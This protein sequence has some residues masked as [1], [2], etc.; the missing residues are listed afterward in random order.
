MADI[1]RDLQHYQ[2]QGTAPTLAKANERVQAARKA[3]PLSDL[4]HFRSVIRSRLDKG[5]LV[6]D[7]YWMLR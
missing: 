1:W 4:F 2:D 6:Y 3:T 7:W 5:N